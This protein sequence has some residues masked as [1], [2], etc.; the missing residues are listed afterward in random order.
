MKYYLLIAGIFISCN[1]SSQVYSLKQSV[2]YERP[3]QFSFITNIPSHTVGYTKESFSNK[4]LY[5]I[6][7]VGGATILL[8]VLDR[9]IT[10]GVQSFTHRNHISSIQNYDPVLQFSIGGKPTNIGKLPRNLNTAIYNLGQGS[11]VVFI[12]AGLFI[13]GKISRDNRA[14][15]T[16]SQLLESFV[17]LG[18]G[19]QIIKYSTG[20]E[21]A[22]SATSPRGTWRPFPT[23]NEFQNNKSR[24]DA[25]PSGHMAT[26]MAGIAILSENYKEKKW[27]KPVGFGIAALCSLAMINNGVHWASDYPLGAAIGY[28]YGKY[29]AQKNNKHLL[30]QALSF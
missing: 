19:T 22:S 8:Y 20:R 14:L 13:K 21:T 30:Q 28:G 16:A 25:F 2:I 11:T 23:W 10:N 5:K 27:I 15:T 17:A 1:L 9:K 29:I 6:G 12:A 26:L 3:H 7:I 24:F 4:N 18:A